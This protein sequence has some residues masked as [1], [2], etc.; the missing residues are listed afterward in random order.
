MGSSKWDKIIEEAETYVLRREW[1][2]KNHRFTLKA[3]INKQREAHNEMIRTKQH[4][5]YE[6]P[7]EHTRVGRLIRSITSRDPAIVSA[8]IHIQGSAALRDN[9]EAA[10]DFL[11]LTAPSNTNNNS[12]QR[13]SAVRGGGGGNNNSDA[14]PGVKKGPNTGIELRYY[15]KKE[16]SRLSHERRKEL[17]TLRGSK[18][19]DNG[20]NNNNS[21]SVSALK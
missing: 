12:N 20:N 1:N 18:G 11:L 7:N 16:Y 6:E 2:G 9:F 4:V 19:S 8:I 10:A 13:V 14:N 21:L 15:T 17:A 5:E 3:N